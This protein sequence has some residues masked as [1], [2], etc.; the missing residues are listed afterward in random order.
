MRPLTLH[1]TLA[2][3][4]LLADPYVSAD[5]KNLITLVTSLDFMP[6]KETDRIQDKISGRAFYIK[7]KNP[8]V[9]ETQIRYHTDA[10]KDT[11]EQTLAKTEHLANVAAPNL[12][13]NLDNYISSVIDESNKDYN[14]NLGQRIRDSQEK[15]RKENE[16][17]DKLTRES[18]IGTF[19]PIDSSQAN[20]VL[21][22]SLG[23]HGFSSIAHPKY[24]CEKLGYEL[25]KEHRE[26]YMHSKPKN[27]DHH[28][29][30]LGWDCEVIKK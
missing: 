14:K 25:I 12:T 28:A 29:W 15:E 1:E 17:A 13:E 26:L 30:L 16:A 5:D 24:A 20:E 8:I 3:N 19:I 2:V 11:L 6:T 22:D 21:N 7:I 10:H 9:E 18:C 4:S 27:T 23:Y